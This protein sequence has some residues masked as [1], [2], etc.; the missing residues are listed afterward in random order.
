M[1]HVLTRV[2]VPLDG[3]S[4]AQ[5]ALEPAARIARQV[6]RP[7]E[8]VTVQDP[9]NGRWARDLDG[10]AES[11]H[12]EDVE[13]EVVCGGWPG[14][15]IVDLAREYP[16]TLVCLAARHRD[17][18]DRIVLGSVSTHV[19]QSG[20]GPVLIVGPGFRPQPSLTRYRRLVVCLDGSPRAAAS[21]ATAQRYAE[22]AGLSIDLVHVVESGEDPAAE[23]AGAEHLAGPGRRLRAAG[24]RVG[25]VVLTGADPAESIA[26]LL[27][28]DPATIA[29]VGSHGRTGLARMLLGSVT[30]DLIER[31]PVPL[32]VTQTT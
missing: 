29:V 24:F 31:S 7:L 21:V 6:G 15:I 10:L 23:R 28:E 12:Y 3:T 26:G 4:T 2:L 13:V 16:G 27:R 18:V 22:H 14:E 9:V 30:M 1:D 11:T 32:L 19:I 25:S 8:L 17:R 5:R 20:A